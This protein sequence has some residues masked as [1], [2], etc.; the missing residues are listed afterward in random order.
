MVGAA[1][2]ISC[3]DGYVLRGH[4]W[5]P[6]SGETGCAGAVVI[7]GATGVKAS[8]YHRY[9]A[10]L[11]ENGFTAIT[12]DYRGIGE[13]RGTTIRNL[14]TNW[15]DWGL[16]DLDAVLGWALRHGQR[17]EV[18]VVGHSFGGF[19]GG[20]AGNGRQVKRLLA[21]GAQHAH[22]RDYRPG[23]RLGF[24]WRWHAVMPA[25]TWWYGYFPGKRLG[26]LED[27]P[28]GVATDWARSPRDFNARLPGT[29]G[30]E[31]RAHQAAF[32]ADTLAVAATDDPFAT[33]A[34]VARGLSYYPNSTAMLV[35]LKPE[36]FGLKEIGHFSLFHTRFRDTFWAGT[37]RW[38]RDGVNPWA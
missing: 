24:W 19:A 33:E 2:A 8:Y 27:L 32:T 25:L 15:Y 4:L 21:V 13:S 6:P 29:V 3:C 5:E 36:D 16:K 31:I 20:L 28:K 18:H 37:V 11:A 17:S 12:F 7:A 1:L 34:A 14:R 23:R 26:W 22:W 38:L 30:E 10:F 35:Q 9:A